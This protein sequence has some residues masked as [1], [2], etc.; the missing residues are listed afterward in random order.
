MT[1]HMV[2]M[3][4]PRKDFGRM[5]RLGKCKMMQNIAK[6]MFKR[7]PCRN[8]NEQTLHTVLGAIY[9]SNFCRAVL[10]PQTVA[11]CNNCNWM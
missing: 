9:S 5:Q 10:L 3:G 6:Q 4:K 11:V 8:S 2:C 7:A 1:N